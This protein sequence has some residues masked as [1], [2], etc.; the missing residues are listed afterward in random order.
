[1]YF[2]SKNDFYDRNSLFLKHIGNKNSGRYRRGSGDRPNQH[3]SWRQKRQLK[4]QFKDYTKSEEFLRGDYEAYAKRK[5]LQTDKGPTDLT[6]PKKGPTGWTSPESSGE[7]SDVKFKKPKPRLEAPKEESK[8]DSKKYVDTTAEEVVNTKTDKK[9]KNKKEYKENSE[10]SFEKS[11][12]QETATKVVKADTEYRK[13][14]KENAEVQNKTPTSVEF[15]KAANATRQAATGI[16]TVSRG[17]DK[18]WDSIHNAKYGNE[19]RS[20]YVRGLTNEELRRTIERI[21]L[22]QEYNKVTMPPKSKGYDRTMAAL[23]ILGSMAT[24]TATGLSIAAGVQ[25]L[26]KR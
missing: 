25:S 2:I 6:V 3:V 13:A 16:D 26:K 7:T 19:D 21:K 18:A 22:D 23:A 20:R 12:D 24:V 4:K 15:T 5:S 9:E 11:Y 17:V 14:V 10:P 1:M 8:K